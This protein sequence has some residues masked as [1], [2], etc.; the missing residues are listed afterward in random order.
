MLGPT[1]PDRDVETE[2][3]LLLPSGFSWP[4]LWEGGY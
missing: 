3:R 4:V 2:E 1:L